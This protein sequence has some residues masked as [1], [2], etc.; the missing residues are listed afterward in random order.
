MIDA[1]GTIIGL[2]KK[3]RN[4]LFHGMRASSNSASAMARMTASGTDSA[5]K[6]AVFLTAM[7]NAPFCMTLT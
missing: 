7:R 1:M 4:W 5:E 3:V 2:K 6:T